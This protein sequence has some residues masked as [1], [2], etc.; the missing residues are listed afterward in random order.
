M[1]AKR[2]IPVN[3]RTR[4]VAIFG[5]PLNYTLSPLFQNAALIERGIDACYLPL[6]TESPARFKALAKGL[7]ASPHFLG[8]N[9][10]NPYKVDALRL[11]HTA[12]AAARAIGAANVFGAPGK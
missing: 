3:G 11:A 7:M 9:V 2:N 1:A 4:L 8:A 12:T 5:W 6:A 10:T